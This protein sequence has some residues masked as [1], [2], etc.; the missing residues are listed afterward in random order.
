MSPIKE[1]IK[2][3]KAN[4]NPIWIMRQAGRYLPEFRKIRKKNPD[5]IKLCLNKNIVPE[6]TLQPLRRFDFDAAIIFSDI[7]MLPYGLGQN[8]N[9]TKGFGPS[10]SKT[11]IK[12][13][14]SVTREE[15][16]KKINPVYKSLKIVSKNKILKNKDLI[17]FVGA[18]WT[19]LVY[20]QNR[21]SPKKTKLIINQSF[22]KT[23]TQIEEIKAIK[24]IIKFLKLHIKKQVDNGASVIQIFDSWAEILRTEKD[25]EKFIYRPNKELADYTKKLGVPVIC[26]PR[27]VENYK[28]FCNIVKPD[29][30]SIDYNVD[31][32]KIIK[33]IDIPIQ[34]GMDPKILLGDKNKIKR[35]A[36]KYLEIFKD[37]PYIFNLGHGILPDTETEKVKYLV[38]L[39]K[40]F[41]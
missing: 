33:Q 39:V 31:P 11:S 21:Q 12:L 7:L 13:M 29:A 19:I 20:M 14:K 26:F 5:F 18:P 15:F 25:R 2:K 3:K 1:C 17:G 36:L 35:E 40:D 6:I 8:V 32:R 27:G 16:L 10:L 41:K 9:F 22:K 30:V 34:G 23:F 4:I 38:N 24:I 28:T 37:H